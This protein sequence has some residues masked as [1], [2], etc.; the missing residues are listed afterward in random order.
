MPRPRGLQRHPDRCI[1][2][3]VEHKSEEGEVPFG[4]SPSSIRTFR[5]PGFGYLSPASRCRRRARPE[6]LRPRSPCA[7]RH[8]SP[9]RAFPPSVEI[10]SYPQISR[11]SGCPAP[12]GSSSCPA[13]PEI[14]FRSFGDAGCPVP[15]QIRRPTCNSGF[16]L[17][18]AARFRLFGDLGCPLSAPPR[19]GWPEPRLPGA[20]AH[21][22]VPCPPR[23]PVTSGSPIRSPW[24]SGFPT[25][26]EPRPTLVNL[27]FPRPLVSAPL[28]MNHRSPGTSWAASSNLLDGCVLLSSRGRL[29]FRCKES[30]HEFIAAQHLNLCAKLVRF[31]QI[32]RL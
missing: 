19:F 8:R 25:L 17:L 5:R 28:L 3:G 6:S 29:L 31:V 9:A 16:P 14:R 20:P 18:P 30:C 2:P 15:P 22:S 24:S 26:P 12:R 23:F 7:F 13:L 27:G 32:T 11:N 1:V 10:C 21:R 4:I